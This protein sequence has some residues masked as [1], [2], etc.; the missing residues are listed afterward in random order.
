MS[1]S[2]LSSVWYT[3]DWFIDLW[4]PRSS[5][6]HRQDLGIRQSVKIAEIMGCV[7]EREDLSP[8]RS[9]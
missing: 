8:K 1:S 5:V 2:A 9:D 4:S 3:R 7:G 6:L